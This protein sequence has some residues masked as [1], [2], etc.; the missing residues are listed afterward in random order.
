MSSYIEF[1]IKAGDIYAPLYSESRSGAIYQAFEYHVPSYS[2]ARALT[3]RDLDE[4]RGELSLER[5]RFEGNLKS[6][7]DK[8]EWLKGSNLPVE[9]R[10]EAYDDTK[11]FIDYC[12]EELASMA[13]VEHFLGFLEDIMEE[14]KYLPD[15]A[16][17]LG[18]D[19]DHYIFAGIECGNPGFKDLDD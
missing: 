4:V 7:N 10:M 19:E 12:N 6:S 16:K 3:Q 18:V 9:E 11:S 1:Y 2:T 5:Q 17:R 15:T 14:V 8:L 13:R